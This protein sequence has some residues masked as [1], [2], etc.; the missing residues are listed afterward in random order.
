MWVKYTIIK[1]SCAQQK[2]DFPQ[3]HTNHSS[4]SKLTPLHYTWEEH[5]NTFQEQFC[6]LNKLKSQDS[7][8]LG[9]F[10]QALRILLTQLHFCTIFQ[11]W[12]KQSRHKEWTNG[13]RKTV[14]STRW[15]IKSDP[16]CIRINL[17]WNKELK[18]SWKHWNY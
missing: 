1:T 12:E 18:A 7:R 16:S 10:S 3:K 9:V 17:Q 11:Q 14:I 13:T 15:H 2:H 4:W 8:F 5:R 6:L